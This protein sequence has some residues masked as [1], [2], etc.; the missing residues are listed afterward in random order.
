MCPV[1]K[2]NGYPL[3]ELYPWISSVYVREDFRGNRISEKLIEF[4][5]H[6]AKEIGFY[7]KS[8]SKSINHLIAKEWVS[9]ME[10]LGYEALEYFECEKYWLDFSVPVY[11]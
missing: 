1:D 2:N 6:Y 8:L 4:A 3:P 10:N 11:E 7:E 9:Y 5:N